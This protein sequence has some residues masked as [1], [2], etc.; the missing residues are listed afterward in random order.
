MAF[1]TKINF[2]V[3]DVKSETGWLKPHD[4]FLSFTKLFCSLENQKNGESRRKTTRTRMVLAHS[5]NKNMDKKN[6]ELTDDRQFPA[7]WAV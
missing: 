5:A 2:L 4:I 7:G 1:P 6:L 3:S